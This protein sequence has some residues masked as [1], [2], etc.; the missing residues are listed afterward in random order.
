MTAAQRYLGN[1]ASIDVGGVAAVV[2]TFH[3]DA[4]E[5]QRLLQALAPQVGRIILV[6]NTPGG[7]ADALALPAQAERIALGE[8]AG[9]AAAQNRGIARARVLGA[10]HCILFDQDSEPA[11][12]MVGV[13]LRAASALRSQGERIAA[14]GP[15]WQD[16]LSGHS[17]GFVRVNRAGR[18][19]SA[20]CSNPEDPAAGC[21]RCDYL[22]AS[23][24]L[25]SLAVLDAVG[26]MDERLFIDQIDIEWCL[27]ARRFGYTCFGV[28]NALLYHRV[29][30]AARRVWFFG[31]RSLPVNSPDRDYY[32]ARN[33]VAL[34]LWRRLPLR[35]RII[36]AKVIA[37]VIVAAIVASGERP[38]RLPGV[39]LGI[40]HGL[41]GRQGPR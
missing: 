15:R 27:R 37:N 24:C 28:C 12:T 34:A 2:V 25:I 9:L 35:W 36:N 33:L 41:I 23:G 18:A 38:R 26:P 32:L 31:W 20:L 10:D 6:D 7:T 3:P 1:G 19:Q 16:R 14:V 29:G 39:A 11:P 21:L 22:I 13:L 17:P 8:N 30:V 5:L 40:V 4:G